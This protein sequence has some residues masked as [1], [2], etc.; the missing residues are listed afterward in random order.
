MMRISMSSAGR[1][2]WVS[3]QARKQMRSSVWLETFS[4]ISRRAFFCV[5]GGAVARCARAPRQAAFEVA[6]REAQRQRPASTAPE[7]TRTAFPAV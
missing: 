3:E 7:K 6:P 2:G 5:C 1:S 4:T